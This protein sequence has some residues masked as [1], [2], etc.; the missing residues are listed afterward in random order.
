MK[1]SALD[2]IGFTFFLI[3][4]ELT[5][6]LASVLNQYSDEPNFDYQYTHSKEYLKTFDDS[7]LTNL[8]AMEMF[9]EVPNRK[10]I[11]VTL[12]PTII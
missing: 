2:R 9:P 1:R 4:L 3:V 12:K 10:D 7:V 8:Q 5:Y 11:N 6:N